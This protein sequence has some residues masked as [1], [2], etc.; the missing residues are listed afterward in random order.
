[1]R[2]L[3]YNVYNYN[4]NKKNNF[5]FLTMNYFLYKAKTS[6]ID[7]IFLYSK[8]TP[9]NTIHIFRGLMQKTVKN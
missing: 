5:W 3:I 1:M 6:E 2:I 8:Y 7:S 9:N 4:G